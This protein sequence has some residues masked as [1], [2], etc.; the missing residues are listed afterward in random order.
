LN[1]SWRRALYRRRSPLSVS[2]ASSIGTGGI[3]SNTPTEAVFDDNPRKNSLIF[4]VHM[5]K[6]V[7]RRADH[8]GASAQP[9][10]GRAVFKPDRE[11]TS[12]DSSRRIACVMSSANSPPDYRRTERK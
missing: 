9:A 6:S 12:R 1:T 2:T 11:P 7:G 5:W 3:L 4:A 8:D 10:Q